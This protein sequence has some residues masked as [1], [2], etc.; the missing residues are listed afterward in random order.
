M[1]IR[2]I[3]TEADYDWALKEIERYFDSEPEPGSDDADRFDILAALVERYEEAHYPIPKADPIEL[4]RYVMETRG[5]TQKDLAALLGSRS[6][7]SEVLNRKRSLSIEM[8]RTLSKEW[9]IPAEALIE[10]YELAA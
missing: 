9:S 3:K 6:R 1:D 8:I 4:I 10:P 7:A 2:P 5:A